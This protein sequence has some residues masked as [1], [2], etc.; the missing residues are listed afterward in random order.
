MDLKPVSSSFISR[1]GY[2]PLAP[3]LRKQAPGQGFVLVEIRGSV[4]AILAPSWTYGLLLAAKSK[5][6]IYNRLLKGLP[7]VEVPS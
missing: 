6:R 3:E 4:K 1:V 2:R 7:S 5:G